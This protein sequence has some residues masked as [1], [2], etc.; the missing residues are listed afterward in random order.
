MSSITR[1]CLLNKVFYWDEHAAVEER[2]LVSITPNR[3]IPKLWVGP[4]QRQ[5]LTTWYIK[6]KILMTTEVCTYVVCVWVKLLPWQVGSSQ[7]KHQILW[8]RQPV[9][10]NQQLSL[11]PAAPLVFSSETTHHITM[12]IHHRIR[13]SILLNGIHAQYTL[14]VQFK[15]CTNVWC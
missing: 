7:H 14:T 2:G 8:S 3:Q 9:H 6:D 10:L 11:H 12:Y 1:N 13:R 5:Y 4:P 15:L